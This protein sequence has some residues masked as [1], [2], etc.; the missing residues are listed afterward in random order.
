MPP[1]PRAFR[2]LLA[3]LACTAPAW[4]GVPAFGGPEAGSPPPAQPS[5]WEQRLLAANK[6]QEL[7]KLRAA[8]ETG[9]AA[10]VAKCEEVLALGPAGAGELKK[11]LAP[12]VAADQSKY[13]RA[14]QAE[15]AKA[16][17]AQTRD[18][19][20]QAKIA[21][22]RAAI[23]AVRTNPTKEA[24]A[25]KA[26]PALAALGKMLLCDA[27]AVVAAAPALRQQ[28]EQ[29]AAGLDMLAKTDAAGKPGAAAIDAIDTLA[30]LQACPMKPQDA[31]V[32]ESVLGLRDQL[33]PAEFEG[34]MHL[35]QIRILAGLSALPV[36]PRLCEA[37]RG[38]S[39]DMKEKGFFSH[40]SPVAGKRAFTD[41]A[42]LAGTSAQAENIAVGMSGGRSAV[43]AWWH[44]PGHFS[45]MM[46]A[47]A[48][49]GL[50]RCEAHWTQMFGG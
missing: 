2:V 39:K 45:N 9:G 33:D 21:E 4:P 12:K 11:Y 18:G 42:K 7:A 19:G 41:R 47:H 43:D 14:F 46:G 1:F 3:C 13:A 36:D 24:I 30:A 16:V 22:H 38:H 28:R 44:S 37:S 10:W 48:R 17:A 27:K 29:L 31:R 6:C 32:I 25:D 49:Q 40:E 35:N 34:V 8:G 26:D 50:G 5:A 15:A 23:A 20:G